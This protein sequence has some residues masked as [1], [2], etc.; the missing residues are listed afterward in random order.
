MIPRRGM[1]PRSGWE[2][3]ATSIFAPA[4]RLGSLTGSEATT[5]PVPLGG[6]DERYSKPRALPLKNQ[7]CHPRLDHSIWAVPALCLPL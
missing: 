7:G 5:A 4:Q 3:V 1:P 2:G 6:Q